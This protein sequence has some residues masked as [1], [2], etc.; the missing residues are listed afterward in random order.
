M[1]VYFIVESIFQR[2]LNIPNMKS[3]FEDEDVDFKDNF[4]REMHEMKCKYYKDKF[5][6]DV[7]N[8]N[9][10]SEIC[11]CYVVGVQWVL[12]YYYTGVPSWSW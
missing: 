5:D 1:Y 10:V 7:V 11:K 4:E 6:L 9:T 3:Y 8:S 2:D 12:S